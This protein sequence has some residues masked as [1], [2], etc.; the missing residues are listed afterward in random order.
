MKKNLKK[1]LVI[2]CGRWGTFIAWY[3]DKIGHD[4]SLFGLESDKG[5]IRL[6]EERR[7]DYLEIS[8]LG[9]TACEKE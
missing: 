5:Y 8:D 4:V 6:K 2:G 1:I 9:V 7:N 3:F